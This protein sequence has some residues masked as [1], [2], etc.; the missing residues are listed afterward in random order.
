MDTRSPINVPGPLP[1]T[2]RPA[3]GEPPLGELLRS[4]SRDAAY[5]VR[6]EIALARAE[7]VRNVRT[8]VRNAVLVVVGAVVAA[9]GA[10]VLLAALVIGVGDLL[11]GRYALGALLV[12]TLFLAAGG[13]LAFAGIRGARR[14]RLAPVTTIA[15][16]RDTGAWARAQVAR[17]RGRAARRRQ[18]KGP[19]A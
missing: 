16:V 5:L 4:L 7:A 8:V 6:Q 14:T 19:A 13:A 9:P 11:G 17:L 2:P 10:M 12:G 15:T 18:P 1:A 3:G